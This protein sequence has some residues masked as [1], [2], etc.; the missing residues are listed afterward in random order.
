MNNPPERDS[1]DEAKEKPSKPALLTSCKYCREDYSWPL[2]D[3]FW[4]EHNKDWVCRECWDHESGGEKGISA[5]QFYTPPEV[6]EKQATITVDV[7]DYPEVV[8][9]QRWYWGPNKMEAAALHKFDDALYLAS[10]ADALLTQRDAEVNRLRE[11]LEKVIVIMEQ[12]ESPWIPGCIA[13]PLLPRLKAAL[14]PP[15]V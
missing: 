5:A 9:L 8:K 3:V 13:G 1:A 2:D 4:S 7:W 11:A 15:T 6:E 14:T 12:G 10:D